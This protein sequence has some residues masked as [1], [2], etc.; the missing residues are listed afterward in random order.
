MA[1]QNEAHLRIYGNRSVLVQQDGSEDIFLEGRPSAQARG[2]H[3]L[4]IQALDDGYLNDLIQGVREHRV[5]PQELDGDQATLL[6]TLVS[7]ITSEVGRAL[8]GLA[9]LVLSIKSIEPNQ[10]VRLHKGGNGGFSW[11]DGLPMRPLD[12]K[13]CTPVLRQQELVRMNNYGIFMTRSLAENYPY[14]VFY[15]AAMRGAKRECF[16]IIDLI[17]D[18]PGSARPMLENLISMLINNSE[19]LQTLGDQALAAMEAKLRTNPGPETI[20]NIITGHVSQSTYGS[21]LL[22]VAMH[23]LFQVFDARGVFDGD[24][25]PLSQMRS[26]NKKHGNVGDIEIVLGGQRRLH[27]LE[28]WDAKYGK[29]YLR[30]E[31]EELSDKLESH[32]ETT[33]AGF[34]VDRKPEIDDDIQSRIEDLQALHG[35][36]IFIQSFDEWVDAQ[37]E[38][39]HQD[40]T[41]TMNACLTAYVE[42]LA[43]RRLAVAPIDEPADQWLEDL[44]RLLH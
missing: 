9:V 36:D 39:Y 29:P 24:L 33:I 21:R 27:V 13:Y 28:A 40:A 34:V 17:E 10:S 22:E 19:R 6:A 30:D 15:K 7:S 32:G 44:L 2:R 23:S 20:K 4:I 31:L 8:A 35:V 12:S 42:S 14:S 38:R 16:T 25:E 37:I 26:A 11:Q 1:Q 3:D 18:A 41:T 5:I 43:R